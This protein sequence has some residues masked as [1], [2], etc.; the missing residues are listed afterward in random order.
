VNSNAS[1]TLSRPG[2][3]ER[4]GSP[5]QAAAAL[6]RG[7][8]V[9]FGATMTLQRTEQ[10]QFRVTFGQRTY[11]VQADIFERLV[12]GAVSEHRHLMDDRPHARWCDRKRHARADA[13]AIGNH[14]ACVGRL[15]EAFDPSTEL[16]I[17]GWWTQDP[18]KQPVFFVDGAS[19]GLTRGE[20][21]IAGLAE[22]RSRLLE[23]EVTPRRARVLALVESAIAD[24]EKGIPAGEQP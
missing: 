16:D 3:A 13:E 23:L 8:A 20:L 19:E 6:N 9:Q 5:D 1:H 4:T 2:S 7:E 21:S 15:I 17:G 24:F 10:E 22:Q 18:G 12:D 11:L 14:E